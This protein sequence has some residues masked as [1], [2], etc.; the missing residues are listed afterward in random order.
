MPFN[1]PTDVQ[2]AEL[3]AEQPAGQSGKNEYSLKQ[4]ISLIYQNADSLH[5]KLN[6]RERFIDCATFIL[7]CSFYVQVKKVK[8][9]YI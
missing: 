1:S 3:P 7:L 6:Q 9:A 2:S 4:K 8:Q 5:F